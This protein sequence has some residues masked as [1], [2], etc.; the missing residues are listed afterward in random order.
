MQKLMF[1]LSLRFDFIIFIIVAAIIAAL[2]LLE[3][4]SV[5]LVAS[6]LIS[7]LM[8]KNMTWLYLA[9]P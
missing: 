5:N 1:L 6:M 2:G 7:P 4:S 3:N 8:G 9:K